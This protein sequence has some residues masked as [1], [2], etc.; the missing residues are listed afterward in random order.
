MLSATYIYYAQQ[1]NH[2]DNYKKRDLQ[3]SLQAGK[4]QGQVSDFLLSHSGHRLDLFSAL[5]EVWRCHRIQLPS[6]QLCA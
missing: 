2:D 3:L 1:S 5:M 4:G 6:G